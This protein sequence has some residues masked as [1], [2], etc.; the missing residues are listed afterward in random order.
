MQYLVQQIGD[1]VVLFEDGTEAEVV[2]F[3]PADG[4][5]AAR[6]QKVIHASGLSDEDKTFAHFWTGYFYAH[7]SPA[8]ERI[9]QALDLISK[10]GDT[11]GLHHKQWVLAQVAAVL[12]AG[13]LKLESEGTCP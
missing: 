13:T 1:H 5:A 3:D 2:R 6:A 9:D 11:D 12:S 8:E 7:L 10:Y 4:N